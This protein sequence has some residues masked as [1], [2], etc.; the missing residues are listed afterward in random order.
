VATARNHKTTDSDNHEIT[1][2]I[3]LVRGQKVMLDRDLAPL[4]GVETKVFNQAVK[5]NLN[6]FPAD[7]MFQLSMDEFQNLRSQ[8]VT[9]SWGG[10][11]YLPF[12]FTEQGVAMLS[13]VLTSDRAIAMN[14]AI[15]R[16]FV[17][18]RKLASFQ[19]SMSQEIERLKERLGEHDAQLTGIYEAIEN[20]LDDK[21]ELETPKD[22]KRIGFRPDE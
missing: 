19:K 10:Q 11:R 15:M 2:R 13:G 14:I 7:F 16:A 17:E 9:S 6:R 12:A 5:R 21:V 4:Y 3:Y 1:S 20:L 8:I 22:R 18:T